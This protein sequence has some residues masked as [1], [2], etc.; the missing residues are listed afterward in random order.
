M[1]DAGPNSG[2]RCLDLGDSSIRI[3]AELDNW[4]LAA[5]ISHGLTKNE[6]A[7]K[8]LRHGCENHE[9]ILDD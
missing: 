4:I 8:F 5:A 2:C 3:D 6:A 9:D 1:S 7:I